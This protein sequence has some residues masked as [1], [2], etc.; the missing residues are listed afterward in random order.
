MPT[1]DL[2]IV[3]TEKDNFKEIPFSGIIINDR[4]R[5]VGEAHFVNDDQCRA[6]LENWENERNMPDYEFYTLME[7]KG[8][9]LEPSGYSSV[10]YDIVEKY[11][12]YI[13]S[14]CSEPAFFDSKQKEFY[15]PV[16]IDE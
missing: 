6:Y 11:Q 16:C 13:C 15:C 1:D 4:Y 14:E 3:N 9:R 8:Y 12:E 5:C 7:E 10:S 2:T